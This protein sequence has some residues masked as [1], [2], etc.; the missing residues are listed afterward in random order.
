MDRGRG[1][2]GNAEVKACR[3]VWVKEKIVSFMFKVPEGVSAAQMLTR[4]S[5]AHCGRIETAW[6]AGEWCSG[7]G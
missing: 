7:K 6:Q 5:E 4:V 2:G 3:R 1:L